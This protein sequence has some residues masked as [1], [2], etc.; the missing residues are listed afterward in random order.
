[1]EAPPHRKGAVRRSEIPSDV[2]QAVNEGRE[3][4]IMLV[5]WL[6]IDMPTLSRS[7]LLGVGLAKAREELGTAADSLADQGVTTRLKRIGEPLFMETRD[8][9]RRSEIYEALARNQ[10][11]MVRVWAAYMTAT[12]EGLTLADR[13]EVTRWFAA[14]HS[15][16]VRECAWDSFRPYVA[17]DLGPGFRLL[18]PWVHDP[19]PGRALLEPVR[20]D[21]SRYVQRSVGNW[22][23]DRQQ[24]APRLGPP[25]L[26]SLDRGVSNQGNRLHR[27]PRTPDPPQTGQTL[28]EGCYAGQEGE[29]W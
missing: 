13:L 12:D 21:P 15:L 20:S 14:D 23:N 19:E 3:E 10:A 22:L 28:R 25:G 29:P 18:E 16:A 26:L 6:A 4:T 7:I 17:A 2:L 24:I 1:M 5:E 8:H 9:P 27:Q 11:D